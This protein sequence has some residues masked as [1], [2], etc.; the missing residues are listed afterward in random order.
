MML[1][2]QPLKLG[3]SIDDSKIYDACTLGALFT[4][5]QR[6]KNIYIL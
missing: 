5:K 2:I 4:I 1:I 6:V 3:I